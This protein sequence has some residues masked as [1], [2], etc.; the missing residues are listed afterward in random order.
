MSTKNERTHEE[1]KADA[2][3]V[4]SYSPEQETSIWYN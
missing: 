2:K 1:M 4:E 3:R